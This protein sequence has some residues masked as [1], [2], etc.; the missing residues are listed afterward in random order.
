MRTLI[1]LTCLLM[2][3]GYSE[4][5]KC[6]NCHDTPPTDR[7]HVVHSGHLSMLPKYGDTSITDDLRTFTEAYAFNCG[8][9]HPSGPEAH[10]NGNVDIEL[11]NEAA[12]GLKALNDSSAGYDR[13]KRK[14]NGVYCHSTGEREQYRFVVSPGWNRE[15]KGSFCHECHDSPPA[16][17]GS[18]KRPNG[19][20]NVERGSGHL[21]GI[22]WDSVKGHS[23]DSFKDGTSSQMGCSTCHYGTVKEDRDTAFVDTV[24]GLFTC[25]RCHRL[26]DGLISNHSLHVNGKVDIEFA[27]VKFRSRAQMTATP[28]GWSRKG[29]KG[30]K[31]SYDEAVASLAIINYEPATHTC[32]NVPCHLEGERVKWSDRVN[33]GNCHVNYGGKKGR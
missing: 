20:F 6:G 33:C 27:P 4:A 16:Y 28:E 21:L 1:F 32:S 7:S 8:N 13:E 24:N 22:H 30:K 23:E 25:V 15:E 26:R 2:L 5:S 17:P 3:A 14:C 19:H 29:D 11:F 18:E 10:R 9:C 12:S 31:G